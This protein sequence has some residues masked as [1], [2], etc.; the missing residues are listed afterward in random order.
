MNSTLDHLVEGLDIGDAA[1]AAAVPAA[2]PPLPTEGLRLSVIVPTCGRPVLLLRCLQALLAQSMPAQAFEIV[3][4]DDAHDDDTRRLVNAL[5]DEQESP[6]LRYLRSARARGGPA[7]ARNLGWRSALG[8]LIAFTDDDTVPLDDW[9]A[10]GEAAMRGGRWAALGGRVLV[11]LGPEPP[12]DHARMTQGLERAEFVTANAFVGRH[13]LQRVHG[14]DERFTRAWREDSDLQFRLQDSAG[15][16]GRCETAVVVHPVRREPWGVSLRQ[17]KNAFFEALL[18]AKH[19][20][21][22]RRGGGLPVP[23]DYYAIVLLTLGV[24]GFWAAGIA[25]SAAVCALL[26]VALVLRFA[27]RRL[28]GT[29][30]RADHVLE[31]LAT[32]ALIPF[33]SV[34]WR[35]RGAW[36]F[37]VPFL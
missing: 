37:K 24:P 4:V 35:L 10:Q 20:Q 34:A 25:G 7:A 6:R 18:Y 19:P 13:A 36:R 11:P 3:V 21:R 32:S 33:L 31:M 22:Y 9:L 26:A 2:P 12:T 28:R 5:A 29:S 17:Q 1:A 23:W 30:H 8:E 15:P 27:L 16:V 14:F